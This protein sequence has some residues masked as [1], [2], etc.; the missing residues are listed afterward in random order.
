NYTATHPKD[1]LSGG[2]PRRST[3]SD[4]NAAAGTDKATFIGRA[5]S[6]KN[7]QGQSLNFSADQNEGGQGQESNISVKHKKHGQGQDVRM[8]VNH[9]ERKLSNVEEVE[10]DNS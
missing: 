3:R 1:G 6:E 8:A 5:V 10:D 9:G 2:P 4:E 7:D